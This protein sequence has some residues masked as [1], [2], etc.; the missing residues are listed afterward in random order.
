MADEEVKHSEKKALIAQ[1]KVRDPTGKFVSKEAAQE[2][3]AQQQA[4]IMDAQRQRLN[5][6]FGRPTSPPVTQTAQPLP[7]QTNPVQANLPSPQPQN[8]FQSILAANKPGGRQDMSMTSE[9]DKWNI[10]LG[11]KRSNI[12]W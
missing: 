3:Q 10:M 9:E 2:L 11:K 8:N 12:R 7:I 4:A 6:L 1:Q 5:T